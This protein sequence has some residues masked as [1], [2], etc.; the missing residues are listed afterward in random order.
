MRRLI[1]AAAIS[2]PALPAPAAEF[3]LMVGFRSVM[4]TAIRDEGYNVPT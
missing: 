2:V 3:N 4:A 1:L